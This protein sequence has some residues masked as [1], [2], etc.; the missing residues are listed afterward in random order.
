M[1]IDTID[2]TRCKLTLTGSCLC[3]GSRVEAYSELV[4]NHITVDIDPK[5]NMSPPPLPAA[6]LRPHIGEL[7]MINLFAIHSSF[8]DTGQSQM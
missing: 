6:L 2:H 5:L 7:V 3:V 4:K 8:D 1:R